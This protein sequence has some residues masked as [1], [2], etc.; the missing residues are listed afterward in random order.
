MSPWRD[1][2]SRGSC[3][4]IAIFA[5]RT[6]TRRSASFFAS[7]PVG[8]GCRL[9][10]RPHHRR[11]IAGPAAPRHQPGT[12]SPHRRAAPSHE[13]GGPNRNEPLTDRNEALDTYERSFYYRTM[14]T[15]S[16]NKGRQT[17]QAILDQALSLATRVGVEGL[18]IGRLAEDLGMSKSGL[19]AHFQTKEALQVQVLETGAH[20]FV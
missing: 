10:E 14:T 13:P 9:L 4:Q 20:R 5:G 17:R 12:F 3:C 1:F 8:P 16:T 19:I 11:R 7:S 6:A 18:T 15:R 2:D